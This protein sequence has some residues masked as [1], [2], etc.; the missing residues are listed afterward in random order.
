MLKISC[1]GGGGWVGASTHYRPLADYSL[2]LLLQVFSHDW[3]ATPFIMMTCQVRKCIEI[4]SFRESFLQD[5]GS[6]EEPDWDS[7]E[8]V[9]RKLITFSLD[10]F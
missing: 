5:D 9:F 7:Y 4:A 10:I 2:K 8:C 3:F 6:F 1:L